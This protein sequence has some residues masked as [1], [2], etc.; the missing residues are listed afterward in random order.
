VRAVKERPIL[1]SGPMV[2]AILDG[3]KTQTR[4]IVR[5]TIGERDGVAVLEGQTIEGNPAVLGQ[6]QYG[7]PGDRLW[8]RETWSQ[9]GG[10]LHYRAD[11]VDHG[12]VHVWVPSI[13]MPRRYS[14]LSLEITEVRV[15]RL[16]EISEA[17]ARAEGAPVGEKLPGTVNG[18][19]AEV[20]A[21]DPRLAFLWLW[22]SINGKRAPWSSNPW[23]WALTFKRV[24]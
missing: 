23:V 4:R 13:H 8:V 19:P 11:E 18:E 3:R 15:Q 10:R 7:R 2:R 5:G 16:Q 21:L 14:R 12:E 24:A 6:C 9:P 17:D 1:F 22:D 20:M